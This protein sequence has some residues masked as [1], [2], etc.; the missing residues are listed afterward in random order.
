M[1]NVPSIPVVAKN[2]KY[3]PKYKTNGAACCDLVARVPVDPLSG[4]QQ[5]VL[6]HRS[7]ADVGTGISVAI[8]DG[9]KLCLAMRS[10]FAKRGLI[11]KNSPGQIDSDYRDE[12]IVMVCNIGREIITINDGDRFAQCWL[13]PVFKIEWIK[14]DMLEPANSNRTGGFGSTGVSDEVLK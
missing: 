8:P 14:K 1:F 6:T 11:C 12:I 10:S 4:K 9:W 7:S 5:I 3:L 13:E 2:D